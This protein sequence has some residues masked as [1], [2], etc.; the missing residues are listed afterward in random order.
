[1]TVVAKAVVVRAVE[2]SGS[3]GKG[4]PRVE[5]SGREAVRATAVVRVAIDRIG[6]MRLVVIVVVIVVVIAETAVVVKG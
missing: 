4:I 1:M 5:A 3:V 2:E 6:Q